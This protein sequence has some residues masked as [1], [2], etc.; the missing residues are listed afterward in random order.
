MPTQEVDVDQI[1]EYDPA[2]LADAVAA[3]LCKSTTFVKALFT[4]QAAIDALF[5][6]TYFQ[7][8]LS[9]CIK[10][11]TGSAVATGINR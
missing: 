5:A 2:D 11:G 9:Q 1:L 7:Q 8:K 4:N 6:N 3:D 10:A